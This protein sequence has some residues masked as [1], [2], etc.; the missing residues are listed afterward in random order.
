MIGRDRGDLLKALEAIRRIRKG[1]VMRVA[2]RSMRL[3]RQGGYA[4]R[5]NSLNSI[6]LWTW[7]QAG[8][9][10]AVSNMVTPSF[11]MCRAT[12]LALFF[13]LFFSSVLLQQQDGLGCLV[14]SHLNETMQLVAQLVG[15]CIEEN[16]GETGIS[17]IE[18]LSTYQETRQGAII[19]QALVAY[20]VYTVCAY[21]EMIILPFVIQVYPAQAQCM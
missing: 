9:P 13:L 2:C 18:N 16:A 14:M 15:V 8:L 12:F 5:K 7:A 20:Y 21:L 1:E 6:V 19:V 10:L 3:S 17:I 11:A 4:V